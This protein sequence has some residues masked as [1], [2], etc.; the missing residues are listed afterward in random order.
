MKGNYRNKMV[1]LDI[2]LQHIH[3]AMMLYKVYTI[4]FFKIDSPTIY[5]SGC[6]IILWSDGNEPAFSELAESLE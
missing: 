1:Y 5:N 4:Y 3:N 6:P 2:I